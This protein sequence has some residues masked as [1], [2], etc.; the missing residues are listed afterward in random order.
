LNTSR[1]RSLKARLLLS[2][3]WL[4]VGFTGGNAAANKPPMTIQSEDNALEM[5]L[6]VTVPIVGRMCGSL[7]AI[8]KV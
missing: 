3:A 5:T 7:S 8:T 1:D 4:L 6:K 2:L